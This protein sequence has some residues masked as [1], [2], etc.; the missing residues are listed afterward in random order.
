MQGLKIEDL[1][2][3]NNDL[4]K[5]RQEILADILEFD[6]E[7][8]LVNG[9]KKIIESKFN[10]HLIQLLRENVSPQTGDILDT[11]KMNSRYIPAIVVK[12]DDD[13]FT[14]IKLND[15][16]KINKFKGINSTSNSQGSMFTKQQ[17]LCSSLYI[18]SIIND[19]VF[20]DESDIMNIYPQITLDWR[21]S[22]EYQ[23]KLI[24][25]FL[26]N[27]DKK[28]YEVYR[29]SKFIDEFYALISRF[30][31]ISTWNPADIWL[32]DIQSERVILDELS[33]IVNYE[34]GNIHHINEYI[35]SCFLSKILIPI[36]LKKI[37]ADNNKCE[38]FNLDRIRVNDWDLSEIRFFMRWS[39]TSHRTLQSRD[40]TF[41]AT[42]KVN[43]EEKDLYCQLKQYPW[44]SG[45]IQ[46]EGKSKKAIARYGKIPTKIIDSHFKQF[47][48]LSVGRLKRKDEILR[49]P[50]IWREMFSVCQRAFKEKFISNF[51]DDTDFVNFLLE[52]DK[53]KKSINIQER[54]ILDNYIISKIE[55]LKYFYDFAILYENDLLS[56]TLGEFYKGALKINELSCVYLKLG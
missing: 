10:R 21:K 56:E 1:Y 28:E 41:Y 45:N 39:D 20:P 47:E 52:L 11:F 38:T 24:Q 50:H 7:I 3:I 35:E 23:A 5:T 22:F 29:K 43:D 46:I 25:F 31:K 15:V 16:A 36:S 55:G 51:R 13:T 18:K 2:K 9:N 33:E 8:E 49:Y 6:S 53:S 14:Q 27:S 37:N 40:T 26:S 42:G 19:G 12:N 30:T 17:E 32:V 4:K 48:S 54:M 34:N 44:M